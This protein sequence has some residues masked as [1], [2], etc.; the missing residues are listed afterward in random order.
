MIDVWWMSL[1]A[2]AAS[3]DRLSGLLCEQE[4]R[5]ADRFV[6]GRDRDRFVA[7]H[8][9]LRSILA[10]YARIPGR[11]LEFQAAPGGKPA[12]VRPGEL[13]F[14]LSHSADR[15]L[16]VVAW[17]REVGVDV[18]TVRVLEDLDDLAASCF[19]AAERRALAAIPEASRLECFFDG[20]TRKEAFLKLSGDGLSRPLCSFD[21][22]LSPGEPARLLRVEG[23]RASDW[24][25]RS[26]DVGPGFRAALAIE[27]Q[28]PAIRVLEW[29][30]DDETG[31]SD[32]RRGAGR[33]EDVRGGRQ[34]GG[35]VLG[36]AGWQG[37]AE[38]MAGRRQ[39]RDEDR[40]PGLGQGGLDRHDAGEPSGRSV[41]EALTFEASSTAGARR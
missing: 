8:G 30:A 37:S 22:T 36:L 21:V 17:G 11:E 38:R 26:I 32:G 4:R 1:T 34:P 31:R 15:A 16:L 39:E 25:L 10:L 7:A 29:A 35:T 28:A 23:G 5:R 13:R 14:N 9:G 20:W 3:K 12:L 41:G 2:T 6:F 40:V 33:H 24:T 18:E 27:G 19:S